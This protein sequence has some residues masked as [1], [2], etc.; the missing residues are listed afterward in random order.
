MDKIKIT[1][2]ELNKVKTLHEEFNYSF[3]KALAGKGD[4][5]VHTMIKVREYMKSLGEKYGYN[6]KLYGIHPKTGEV[7]EH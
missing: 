6:Y 1:E 2:D 5:T 3:A 7:H 4:D